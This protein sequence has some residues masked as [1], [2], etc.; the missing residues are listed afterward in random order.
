MREIVQSIGTCIH[1]LCANSRSCLRKYFLSCFLTGHYCS[2]N[3]AG[4]KEHVCVSSS[5]SQ[6]CIFMQDHFYYWHQ[7]R[8][9]TWCSHQGDVGTNWI[10][11]I[12]SWGGRRKWWAVE[13][14]KFIAQHPPE[15]LC[16]STKS[17]QN[18]IVHLLQKPLWLCLSSASAVVRGLL[19][20]GDTLPARARS[21]RSQ[22]SKAI[23]KD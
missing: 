7:L 6:T 2:C 20:V 15:M 22:R 11:P 9:C 4:R 13:G 8:C 23:N 18:S 17:V 1:I 16:Q 12:L 10:I 5:H 19:M 21:W 3:C 14:C